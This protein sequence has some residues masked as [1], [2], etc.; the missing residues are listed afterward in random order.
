MKKQNFFPGRE[1]DS[2]VLTDLCADLEKRIA[3][4]K[5]KSK[6]STKVEAYEEVLSLTLGAEKKIKELFDEISAGIEL[7]IDGEALDLL[8]LKAQIRE[9]CR[10]LIGKRKAGS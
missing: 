3:S 7:L 8:W 2:G 4:L 6:N 5:T 1:Y 9:L 10:L